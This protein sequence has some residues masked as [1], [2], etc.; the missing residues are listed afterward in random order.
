MNEPD[1]DLPGLYELV[2]VA[3]SD[4]AHAQAARLAAAGAE[5]GTLV[6]VKKQTEG[7]GRRG[8][9]WISGTGNLHCAVVLRPGDSLD[10]CVQLSLVASVCAGR[11]IATIGEPMEELRLGWP[12]DLYLN[13]GKVAGVHVGGQLDPHGRVEWMIV[14]LNVNTATHPD[15][16]G[17]T[18]ASLRD[19]GFACWD[20]VM[21]LE[22]FAREF[23]SWLNRWAEQGL[24]PVLKAWSWCGG[25]TDVDCR[26]AVA[27]QAYRGAFESLSERG[28]L[29]LNTPQGTISV[30]LADFYAGEFTPAG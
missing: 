5:E 30:E 28:A 13:R 22:S 15:S 24:A 10:A 25:G 21:L 6:W 27:G 18:T 9:F 16:L 29:R 26:V 14:S 2:S 8:N 4:N 17:F 19:E 1:P 3:Q 7:L 12:N 23:L 11:A 20:R